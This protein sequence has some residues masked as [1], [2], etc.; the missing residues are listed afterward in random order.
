VTLAHREPIRL[1]PSPWHRHRGVWRE[2]RKDGVW[3]VGAKKSSKR[4]D[5]VRGRITI[6]VRRCAC[7]RID[8]R[9]S[10]PGGRRRYVR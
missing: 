4:A 3:M 10:W 9:E 1:G 5:V 6:R 2:G 8:V 7:G